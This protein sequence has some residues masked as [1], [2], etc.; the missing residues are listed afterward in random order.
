MC[1]WPVSLPSSNMAGFKWSSEVIGL[2]VRERKLTSSSS[3]MT[4][5]MTR[6]PSS[7]RLPIIGHFAF[8]F[9]LN[10]YLSPFSLYAVASCTSNLG[11][12][13]S[14]TLLHKLIPTPA[15]GSLSRKRRKTSCPSAH[16]EATIDSTAA[17][18]ALPVSSRAASFSSNSTAFSSLGT[19]C[20]SGMATL[21]FFTPNRINGLSISETMLCSKASMLANAS[22]L[23]LVPIVLMASSLCFKAIN[24]SISV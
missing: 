13:V 12:G 1:L 8:G 9:G 21:Y 20:S 22:F 15:F 24:F 23:A 5:Q 3:T 4:S 11:I 17:M 16:I 2:P 19:D 10:G 7:L 6:S 14:N 18:A